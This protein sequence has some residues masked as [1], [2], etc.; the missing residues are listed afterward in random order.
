M[1]RYYQI[2]LGRGNECAEECI[3][4]HF[5]GVDYGIRQDL[6]NDLSVDRQDFKKKFISIYRAKRPD[7]KKGSISYACGALWTVGKELQAGDIVLSPKI[8]GNYAAGEISG[9]YHYE[10]SGVLPHRRPIKW[11]SHTIAK[12]DM[13]QELQNSSGCIGT[14]C[15]LDRFA[16]EIKKLIDGN[17][18]E[19]IFSTDETIQDPSVF[20]LEV[21][22]EDFLVANWSNIEL[23]KNYELYTDENGDAIGKQ[24][25]TEVGRIDILA[26]SKDKKEYLVIEL[27]RGR[28]SDVVVG[29]VLRYM[30]YVK[31]EMA[32][33]NE[34]VKG[35]V[36][37][38]DDDQKMKMALSVTQN[39]EFFRYRVKFDLFKG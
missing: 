8:D 1:K 13:S 25:P 28:T 38:L 21:H 18:P 29:Q 33:S 30:G 23:F 14:W 3:S 12:S 2:R 19:K 5:I 39:I 4:G 36:I 27:K 31:E 34:V 11:Y 17:S 6:D 37:A 20:A 7:A 26:V 16:E 24:Y 32:E 9:N 35:V 22:L 15:N 10:P